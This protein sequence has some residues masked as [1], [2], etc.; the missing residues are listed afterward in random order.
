MGEERFHGR[1]KP[2]KL[3]KMV[4]TYMHSGQHLCRITYNFL[5]SARKHRVAAFKKSHV[6]YSLTLG[7]MEIQRKFQTTAVPEL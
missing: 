6:D 2:V 4:T 5:H 1:H 3:Q 7:L